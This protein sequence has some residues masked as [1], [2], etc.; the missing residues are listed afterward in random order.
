MKKSGRKLLPV[1]QNVEINRLISQ[2]V[3]WE[4]ET[5][6]LFDELRI[7]P[8]WSCVDLGCGPIGILGPLSNRV[9]IR[10]QVIGLDANPDCIIAANEFIDQNHLSNVKVFS[11]D[12]YDSTLKP[13]SFNLTHARFVFTQAGC[14]R[15]LL[16]TMIELTRSGGVIISQESDW[17][18]WNCYPKNPSWQKIRNALIALYENEGGDINAGQRTYKMFKE[19]ALA[20]VQIHT[21]IKALPFGHSYRAG[22]N[23]MASSLREKI[24]DANILINN[25]FDE[26]F[27]ECNKIINDPGTIIF[28]YVLCQVWGYVKRLPL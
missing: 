15:L 21:T 16:E 9:G 24:I 23:L 5:E 6:N 2:A 17:T 13:D 19:A 3:C 7:S 1:S 8:G 18:T 10:G 4:P 26:A 12:L 25:E 14:D 22:M 28:S 11:G 27:E 20:D